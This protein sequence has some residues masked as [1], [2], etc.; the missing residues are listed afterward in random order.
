MQDSDG[1]IAEACREAVQEM[2]DSDNDNH[3]REILRLQAL[4]RSYYE[5]EL[6]YQA[7]R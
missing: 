3:E 6:E 2:Y 4:V 5:N 1:L 7:S